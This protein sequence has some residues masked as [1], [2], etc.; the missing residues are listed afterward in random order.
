MCSDLLTC[1][2]VEGKLWVKCGPGSLGSGITRL[3]GSLNSPAGCAAGHAWAARTLASPGMALLT[4]VEVAL[5][6]EAQGQVPGLPDGVGRDKGL[7]WHW[8]GLDRAF[9]GVKTA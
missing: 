1:L 3:V 8:G 6:E 7:S 2:S 4:H 9:L 5:G